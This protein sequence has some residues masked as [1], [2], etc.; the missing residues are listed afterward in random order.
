MRY[1]DL[2]RDTQQADNQEK[3]DERNERRSN[4]EKG[5]DVVLGKVLTET[6]STK[7]TNQTKEAQFPTV[8]RD[9]PEWWTGAKPVVPG[10]I[11]VGTILEEHERDRLVSESVPA[12]H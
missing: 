1:L 4:E 9:S 7:E 6:D 10:V 2:I 3:H 11:D 5:A 8:K 12:R